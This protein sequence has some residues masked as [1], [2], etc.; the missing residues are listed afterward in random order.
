MALED[1]AGGFDFGGGV[2]VG[3]DDLGEDVEGT[4]G[5][6]VGAVGCLLNCGAEL[7]VEG[8]AEVGEFEPASNGGWR[9]VGDGGGFVVAF[10]GGE[11]GDGEELARG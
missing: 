1:D 8:G 4:V 7:L 10:A 11:G 9:H 6:V 5:G 3:F 2:G